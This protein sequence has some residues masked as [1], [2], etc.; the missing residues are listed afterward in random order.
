MMD[1]VYLNPENPLFD[2]DRWVEL[3]MSDLKRKH[4][5]EFFRKLQSRSLILFKQCT[6]ALI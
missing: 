3:G 6:R 1:V 2:A 5:K 4:Y